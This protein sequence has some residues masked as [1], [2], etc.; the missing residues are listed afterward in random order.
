ME[1]HA[2]AGVIHKQKS[3]YRDDDPD[4]TFH[5][6]RPED[7]S[8]QLPAVIWIHG[9][10]WI[11]GGAAD[12]V[13]YFE[14]IAEHGYTV[15]GV[16]YSLGPERIYPTAVHQLNDALSYINA[17]AERL[18]VDP[19]RIV[20]AG[21]SAGAQL[22]T[23]LSV[24]TTNP[25]YAGELGVKPALH[26][27]QLRG[28]VLNCGIYDVRALL[29][30]KGLLGWGDGI[31]IWAYTG[32]KAIDDSAAVRQMSTIHH[33]NRAHPPVYIS[34]GNGDPLTKE[35]SEPMAARLAELGIDVTTLF[36][37][38]NHTPPLPHEYQ[39][40]LDNAEGRTAF[41]KTLEFLEQ[42]LVS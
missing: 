16:D 5:L 29:G 32:S 38:T 3:A 11:S 10:A 9:G 40:N 22:A 39:F 26:A 1:L 35:Q 34:G 18:H 28:V 25:E 13:P 19:D 17:H 15:I 23:Q 37:P 33:V 36:W 20:L 21:D 42:R 27:V 8:G 24:L 30:A 12:D 14:L 2:P 7:A 4:A 41:A 6:Y 31:A